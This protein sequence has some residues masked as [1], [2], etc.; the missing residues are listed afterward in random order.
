MDVKLDLMRDMFG[1]TSRA[2]CKKL[3]RDE[4]GDFVVWKYAVEAVVSTFYGESW[5]NKKG[6]VTR[7]HE[8]GKTRFNA[9]LQPV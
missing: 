1:A 9:A 2:I 7:R 4:E 6:D 5:G 3:A 8:V